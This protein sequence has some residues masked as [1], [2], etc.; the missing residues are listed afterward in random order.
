MVHLRIFHAVFCESGLLKLPI[1]VIAAVF[2]HM[3]ESDVVIWVSK[4]VE[5]LP[6][7]AP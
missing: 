2:E 6:P 3:K 5:D 4:I 7:Q 1:E